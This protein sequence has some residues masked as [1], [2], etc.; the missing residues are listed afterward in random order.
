MFSKHVEEALVKVHAE[1]ARAAAAKAAGT[2][3]VEAAE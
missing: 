2:E 1:K 3:E